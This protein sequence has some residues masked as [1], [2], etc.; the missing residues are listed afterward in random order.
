MMEMIDMERFAKELG[1]RIAE[2]RRRSGLS[3]AQ[4]A[5]LAGF[6]QQMIADYETGRRRIPAC[7][8][9]AIADVLGVSTVQLLG[10]EDSGQRGPASKIDRVARQI[11]ELPRRR[12]KR[13]TG[14]IESMLAQELEELNA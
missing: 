9:A 7:N 2:K 11:S 8:L 13:I 10:T 14:V 12:Q 5:K 3:Q 4:M 1:A 6:S